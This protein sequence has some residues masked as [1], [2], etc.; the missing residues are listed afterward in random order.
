MALG[1][2][3][4]MLEDKPMFENSKENIDPDEE[5]NVFTY[6]RSKKILG[7]LFRAIDERLIFNDVQQIEPDLL[8]S[9]TLD[10]GRSVLK[11]V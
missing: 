7:K 2:H 6:Y 11:G 1:L 9:R 3:M 10:L 5:Y 4:K 8:S